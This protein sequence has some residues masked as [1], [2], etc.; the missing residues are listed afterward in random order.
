MQKEYSTDHPA[1]VTTKS[2]VDAADRRVNERIEGIMLGLRTRVSGLNASAEGLSHKLNKL[3]LADI[4]RAG[5]TR[6]YYEVKQMLEEQ[7]RFRAILNMKLAS[8]RIDAELPKAAVVEIIDRAMP[9]LR[10][11]RPNKPLNL[12]IGASGGVVLATA[13]AA[14]GAWGGPARG[15]N[16]PTR[17]LPE[18]RQKA[19]SAQSSANRYSRSAFDRL[20]AKPSSP[21]TSAIVC[22]LLCCNSQIFSSTVPG[23]IRR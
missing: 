14:I 19:R 8:E 7:M 5:R 23:A 6:P 21:S 3:K 12:F 17:R 18:A 15:A 16:T 2:L 9:G 20:R 11:V 4:E 1:C 10:P 22:A 13:G